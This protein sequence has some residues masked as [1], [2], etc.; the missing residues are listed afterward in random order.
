MAKEV[1]EEIKQKYSVGEVATQTARVVID[2]ET[3]AA[4]PIE[5][6]ISRIMNDITEIKKKF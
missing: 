4:V 5:E 2:N 6:A 1:K 3:G